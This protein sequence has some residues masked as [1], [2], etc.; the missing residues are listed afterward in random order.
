MVGLKR[1]VF[2]FLVWTFVVLYLV[3]CSGRM[4]WWRYLRR[5][6]G[7]TLCGNLSDESTFCVTK[8]R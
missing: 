2:L 1:C 4:F 7:A 5:T 8:D 3:L 6:T